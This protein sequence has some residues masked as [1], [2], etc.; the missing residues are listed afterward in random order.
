MSDI[1]IE[2][3]SV[4][5]RFH[6][7]EFHD[8][9]RDLIPALARRMVGRGPKR[10]E[11]AEGDFWALRDVSFQVRQGEVLGIIGANGAGKSTLL[12][13]LA[14]ILKPNR[15]HIRVN[16]RLR[17]LIEVAAGFH[18]DLTGRENI[19][20]NGSILGMKKREIDAKFD[21]IVEFSGIGDFLDTPVKRY[22]S[23]MHARLGFA[24]AAHLEPEVLIVDEVL[25]VGDQAFQ[26]KCL[27]KMSDVA[28]SGRTVLFVSHNL[29]A[30]QEL[31]S[32]AIL[33]ENG[34]VVYEGT[35]G[36]AVEQYLV[37]IRNGMTTVPLLDR[38][39]RTGTGRVRIS[40]FRI[41]CP[42]GMPVRMPRCGER[43]CLAIDYQAADDCRNVD[44]GISIYNNAGSI[45][46]VLYA[47][48]M[49]GAFQSIPTQG[50]F[51]CI[52]NR[53]PLVPGYYRVSARVYENGVEADCPRDG[54]GFVLVEEGDY[55]GTGHAPSH[56][57]ASFFMD[58]EW[59]VSAEQFSCENFSP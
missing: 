44:I 5:K 29:A 19:Y 43:V 20:L 18:P 31:C 27:G 56:R 58:G 25:A 4:W 23:G 36:D 51:R 11:L 41:E 33:L 16:G 13:I 2:V 47:S 35:A 7:G 8:S 39:G 45:L 6:R 34:R 17:A 52:V 37:Q 46:S 28:Q 3:D 24:V 30:V 32:R 9:L 1:A 12:K 53:L 54:V 22:S 59:R 10:D 40:G 55:Y 15:G 48:Y 49:R 42:Q 50:T 38:M 14:K 26:E 21:E 57:N